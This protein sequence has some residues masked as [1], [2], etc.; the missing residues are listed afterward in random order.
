MAAANH[1]RTIPPISAVTLLAPPRIGAPIS[2]PRAVICVAVFHFAARLTG[3]ITLLPARCSRR[4]ETRISRIRIIR[5]GT[6]K[7]ASATR[8]AASASKQAATSSLSAI[9]SSMRPTGETIF[10]CL[11]KYPSSQSEALAIMNRKRPR[12]VSHFSCGCQSTNAISGVS[13]IR[14][15]V[16]KFGICCFINDLLL[17]LSGTI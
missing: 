10:I 6:R 3:T 15:P 16:T 4:P 1:S 11:A 8:L 12:A 2:T 13:A 9:G 14:N 5:A 17:R 7:T